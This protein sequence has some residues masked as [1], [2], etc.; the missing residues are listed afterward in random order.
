MRRR[1]ARIPSSSSVERDAARF[2]AGASGGGAI[3][4]LYLVDLAGSSGRSDPAGAGFDEAVDQRFAHHARPMRPGTRRAAQRQ[5]QRRARAVPRLEAD[6]AALPVPERAARAAL[7]CCISSSAADRG[8]TL[9]T[10]EF[11]SLA[12]RVTLKPLVGRR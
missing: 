9:S 4:R 10:L 7:V 3:G 2:A 1:A 11:G 5:G 12:M 8:E 6:A